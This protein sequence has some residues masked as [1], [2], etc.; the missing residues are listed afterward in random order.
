MRSA[1]ALVSSNWLWTCFSSESFRVTCAHTSWLAL[2]PSLT[3]P[4]PAKPRP[5]SL[6]T[7]RVLT[8]GWDSAAVLCHAPQAS[9]NDRAKPRVQPNPAP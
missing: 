5:T 9:E 4:A 7:S 2:G 3:K 8:A 6:Y 1:L